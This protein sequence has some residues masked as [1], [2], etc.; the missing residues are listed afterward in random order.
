MKDSSDTIGNG[1]RNLSACSAMFIKYIKITLTQIEKRKPMGVL[2]VVIL[3]E[4]QWSCQFPLLLR[5]A[6]GPAA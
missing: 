6:V 5:R 2:H 4:K 1:T 3:S